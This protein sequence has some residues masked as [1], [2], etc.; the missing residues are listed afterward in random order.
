MT[1]TH[2]PPEHFDA[3]IVGSGF[4]GS[5]TA[6]RL[7]SAGLRV[8]VLERG[9]T[10]PPGS[11]ARSPLEMQ[12]NLWDPS[13]G[14][15]GLFDVW[16]FRGLEAVVSSGLG[17]GSLIYANV[18]IRKDERWFVEESPL[19]GGGYEHW[20]ISR[21]DLDP[22]YDAVER[23]LRA[24]PYPVG[25]EPYAS[26]PK[27]VAMRDAARRLGLDWDLPNLAVSFAGNGG[28]PVPGEA[29][30]P[31]E[32]PNLHGRLRTT[33][34]LCGECDI[35]CNYGSKNTLDHTYLSAAAH[36]GAVLRT[37]SEVRRIA[38][39]GGGYR[40][41]YVTHAPEAE[42][43]RTRTARLPVTELTADRLVLAAGA[44]G[45]PF[46]LLRNRA[47]F[48]A[49]SRALGTRFSGNGDLLGF[50]LGATHADGTPRRIEGSRGP[51]ITS[52][53]RVPD[54]TDGA[55]GRG[56][57]VEDAG[58]PAFAEW[59]VEAAG[60]P[61]A[62]ARMARFA[63]GRIW[64]RLSG[65]P[66]SG[67]GSELQALLGDA[68]FSAG[69]LP[70]L[71]MGRDVPDGVLSLRRG[72]LQVDW[73]SATSTA[74][75]EGVRGVMR[76]LAGELGAGFR[77]NPIWHLR[78]RVITVHPLGGAPMGR[79]PR[80]GVVDSYGEVFGHPGMYV[81]D[82]AAMPGPVGANPS[83]TIAA[84]ADR[85]ADHLLDQHARRGTVVR[86][87][88]PQDGHR[89]AAPAIPRPAPAPERAPRLW[90]TE[91]MKGF[92]ALGEDDSQRGYDRGRAEGTALSF[93]LTITIEDVTR[94]LTDPDRAGTAVGHVDCDALG[95][96]LPVERGI[97]NLF[98][99]TPA[100]LGD[101]RRARMLYRLLLRDGAGNPVTLSGVKDVHDDPGWDVWR[102]TS[103]LFVRLYAGHAESDEGAALLGSGI[104][105]IHLP[106]FLEQL[107]TLRATGPEPGDAVRAL[108]AFGS[109]FLG[110]LWTIYGPRV[111]DTSGSGA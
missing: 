105:T 32:Y 24:R 19:P 54:E 100:D 36:A 66:R 43:H 29:I 81:A 98:V 25:S 5:V 106:D 37:R 65:S 47:A 52:R 38:P 71:G 4:G 33:C 91:E 75:F 80:E 9:K 46:L 73:T 11:F 88:A 64:A 22:H 57:Y 34:R 76:D 17:G 87:T 30:A 8:C 77:D 48:P 21:A 89:P 92:V 90:F 68:A 35:G 107:T 94:F 7:A 51:V 60:A 59:M 20:P 83:L 74:Y 61:A 78:R 79:H 56:S 67:L 28:P 40:I 97:F 108:Q 39:S 31:Y 93:R 69:S 44:L 102:D 72:H 14:L 111:L 3:V 101:T 1:A 6:Y 99:H 70:L 82:G 13:E 41:S 10:Y 63:A 15:Q 85:L 49:L 86:S 96:R 95:G 55:A 62:A 42:G 2:E 50:V 53:I 110:E 18:L 12:R 23:M 103:T 26:T 104:I 58:Y 27:T 109:V 16:S 45:T 84:F